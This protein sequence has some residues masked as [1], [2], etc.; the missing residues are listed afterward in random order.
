MSFFKTTSMLCVCSGPEEKRK[1]YEGLAYW[2]ELTCI[3]F[4]ENPYAEHKLYF[5]R[6]RGWVLFYNRIMSNDFTNMQLSVEWATGDSLSQQHCSPRYSHWCT[7]MPVPVLP[8]CR[9]WHHTAKES[10]WLLLL[11][12]INPNLH[13]VIFRYNI[14]IT[15]KV[16]D[17]ERSIS[18]DAGGKSVWSLERI[19]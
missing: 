6:G 1:I 7:F 15:T 2:Q 11:F 17:K 13:R 3:D 9:I 16:I 10:A 19:V 4:V 18:W 12:L 14:R 8:K 5:V